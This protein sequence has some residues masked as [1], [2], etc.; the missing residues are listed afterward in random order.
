[1]GGTALGAVRHK[2]FIP[3]DDDFDVFMDYD[4]YTKFINLSKKGFTNDSLYIQYENSF[5]WPLLY[6]K[7]RLNNTIYDEI[8]TRNTKYHRG[9]FIDV[10]CLNKISNSKFE[11]YL[12]YI[13]SKLI[14]TKTLSIRSYKTATFTKKILMFI[15]NIFI[16]KEVLSFLIFYVRKFNSKNTKLIGHLFGKA[17]RK[18]TSF[19]IE[20]ITKKKYVPFENLS[21]PVFENVNDYLQLRFGDFMTIPSNTSI[22]KTKHIKHK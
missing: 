17:P 22:E 16:S 7:I 6:S 15:V 4:N 11:A 5:E 3:W 14:I 10:F 19:P 13:C 9:V 1:M 21:L 2:G 18:K 12:Q 8:D 20:W